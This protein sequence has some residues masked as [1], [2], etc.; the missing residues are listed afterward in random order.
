MM[1]KFYKI[2]LFSLILLNLALATYAIHNWQNKRS[3]QKLIPT[4]ELIS[5]EI[6]KSQ[7]QKQ[8]EKSANSQA[9]IALITSKTTICK[10]NTIVELLKKLKAKSPNTVISILLPKDTSEQEISN[11]KNNLEVNFDVNRQEEEL[12]NYWE[13]LAEKYEA[14]GVVVSAKGQEIFASQNFL[15]LLKHFETL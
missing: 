5:N 2:T 12:S 11:F 14:L 15:E 7:M 3:L 9:V 4:S 8:I 1:K 10:R 6:I 13:P